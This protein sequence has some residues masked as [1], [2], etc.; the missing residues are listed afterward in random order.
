M[1]LWSSA[2]F[3]P[4]CRRRF[5]RSGVTKDEQPPLFVGDVDVAACVYQNVFRLAYELIVRGGHS[6][7]RW[8]GRNKPSC[9][10][11]QARILDVEDSQTGVEVSEVNQIAL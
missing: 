11:W 9:F 8:S 1:R 2:R 10:R 4:G 5:T 7:H 3:L 6:A